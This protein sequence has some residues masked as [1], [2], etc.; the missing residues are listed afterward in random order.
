M[1]AFFIDID[2]TLA[3]DKKII[4][5]ENKLAIKEA[6]KKGHLVFINTGRSSSRLPDSLSTVCNCDGVITSLGATIK[7]HGETIFT[8]QT[9]IDETIKIYRIAKK[10][11]WHIYFD[12]E[13][14]KYEIN[15][16]DGRIDLSLSEADRQKNVL[17][18]FS[19]KCHLI[20]DEDY[21]RKNDIHLV[22]LVAFPDDDSQDG[23]EIL[24]G[25]SPYFHIYK[26]DNYY[27]LALKNSGKDIA[28]QKVMEI[29]GIKREDTIAIGDSENDSSMLKFAGI[30]VALA[31]G[32]EKAKMS[33]D[34]ICDK[35]NNESAV[36]DI[37]RR[38]M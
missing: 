10:T 13:Y 1:K 33:A 36:A 17:L 2:G 28:I 30:G 27:D 21:I 9:T 26:T 32:D 5:E 20:T 15:I 31:N 35:T 37:I 25:L 19:D 3:D 14:Q 11:N 34:Y 8:N 29:M 7:F 4:S 16:P 38:F 6:Q 12:T 23:Y 22:K 18:S 24:S